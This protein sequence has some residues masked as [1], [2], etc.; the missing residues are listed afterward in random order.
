MNVGSMCSGKGPVFGG[1]RIGGWTS[2]GPLWAD[3]YTELPKKKY[4]TIH[5]VRPLRLVVYPNRLVFIDPRHCRISS[6]N[7]IKYFEGI[8]IIDFK[9]SLCKWDKWSW[10]K[11]QMFFCSSGFCSFML[12]Y[13]SCWISGSTI[14]GFVVVF[15]IWLKVFWRQNLCSDGK[16]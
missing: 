6:I 3:D 1:W 4:V 2:P 16:L 12:S 7:S 10:S 13:Q 5:D 11:R 8:K 9:V 14:I 15:A